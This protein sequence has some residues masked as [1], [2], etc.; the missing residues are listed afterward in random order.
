M[1]IEVQD[2]FKPMYENKEKFIILLTGGRGG[3]KSFNASTFIERLSFQEGHKI[4]YSRY[5]LTSAHISIIPEFTEKIELEGTEKHF[6]VTKTDIENLYS[7]S[8]IMFRGIKTSSGNQ[9][10]NLKSIQGLTT[11]VG[12]EMEEWVSEKD[13]DKLALSI[14]QKGIQNR[15]ILIMNP[16]DVNHWVYKKYIEKTHEIR[17]IDGVEVQI[18]THPNVLHIHSTY[19]DNLEHLSEQFLKDVAEMKAE[20]PKKY[21]HIIIGRWADVA[22]GVIFKSFELVDEIPNFIKKRG[23]GIDFGYSNDVTAIVDCA[24]HEKDL[25]LDELCYKTRML[26][27]EIITELKKS[28]TKVIADSADPRL[29]QEI[30]NA[31]ILIY[32]ADKYAG[33]IVA[34]IDKML[35]YNLKITKRSYNLLEERRNYTWDRDKDGN[36][37]NKPI[38]KYNHCFVGKTLVKTSDGNTRIDEIKVGDYVLTSKGFRPVRK[39]F[40][41]GRKKILHFR[42]IFCNFVV[43]IQGTPDHKIKTKEKWKQLQELTKG[44]VL[45]VCKSLTKKNIN[46]IQAKDISR[47]AQKDYTGLFG[48]TTMRKFRKVITCITRTAIH[49]TMRL[50]ILNWCKVSSIYPSIF[51]TETKTNCEGEWRMLHNLPKNGTEA[52]RGERGTVNTQKRLLKNRCLKNS[53]VSSADVSLWQR[54]TDKTNFA[55]TNANPHTGYT[56]KSTMKTD[57]ASGADNLFPSINTIQTNFAEEVAVENTLQALEVKGIE[58]VGGDICEVF[59]LEVKDVHEYVANGILVHNC[60]DGARYWVLGEILGKILIQQDYDKED[61][62]IW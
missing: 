39:V 40:N 12:D 31:G 44:D 8:V 6:N 52:M 43:E 10:A 9:T 14:R 35:E 29:I 1:P 61:L 4:L 36:F 16:S 56:I 26:T 30:A 25:Y 51:K 60:F 22:E 21:A 53:S 27:G 45:Y 5:T 54:K 18:S 55:Q 11:F 38:D 41:N 20:N 37:I 7:G 46:C 62:G 58:I 33:S 47:V 28:D 50:K 13:F 57:C 32:P 24:V 23:R 15:V 19:L 2:I 42:I 59:D 34:G 49:L 17:V 48:S 3:A